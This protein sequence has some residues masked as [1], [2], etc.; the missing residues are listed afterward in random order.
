MDIHN[1]ITWMYHNWIMDIHN[2]V[3]EI[4]DLIQIDHDKFKNRCPWLKTNKQQKKNPDIYDWI[5]GIHN[6]HLSVGDMN[7]WEAKGKYMITYAI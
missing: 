3:M 6:F 7:A 1:S 4:C 5:K 2:S